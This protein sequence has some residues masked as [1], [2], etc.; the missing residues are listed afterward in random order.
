MAINIFTRDS[1]YVSNETKSSFR[2][3]ATASAA[4][5]SE[6]QGCA[7]TVNASRSIL[8]GGFVKDRVD[9]ERMFESHD[10]RRRAPLAADYIMNTDESPHR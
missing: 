9:S 5:G 6:E 7:A 3:S 4:G 10:N 8:L 1:L 2:K